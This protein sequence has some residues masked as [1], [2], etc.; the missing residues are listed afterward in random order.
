MTLRIRSALRS[1]RRRLA[2][3]LTVLLLGGIVASHHAEP[4]GMD[5]GMAAGAVCLAVLGV[6]TA[7]LVAEVLPRWSP[8]FEASP[9]PRTRR[10]LCSGRARGAPARA[11]PSYLE[12][13]VLRR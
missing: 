13:S 3:V 5:S 8:R 9:V 4:S 1:P 12:L 7:L 11:G 2:I 10:R 6:G